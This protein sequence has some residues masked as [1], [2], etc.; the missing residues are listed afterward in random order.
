MKLKIIKS[1]QKM[2]EKK[3]NPEHFWKKIC[4]KFRLNDEIE[5]K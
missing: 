2:Q 3:K 5:N 4:K 1:L